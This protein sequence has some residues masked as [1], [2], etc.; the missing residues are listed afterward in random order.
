MVCDYSQFQIDHGSNAC[1]AT[2]MCCCRLFLEQDLHKEDLHRVL[3]AGAILYDK[4]RQQ[5]K[6]DPHTQQ[7]WTCVTKS[8][9]KLLRR[10]SPVFES[11]G[12]F[13]KHVDGG[14]TF[15]RVINELSSGTSRRSGVLTSDGSSYALCYDGDFYYIF[16]SHGGEPPHEDEAVFRRTR[17]RNVFQAYVANEVVAN[18]SAQFSC[19]LFDQS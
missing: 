11:N 14:C 7:Y 17:D 19:V 12:F 1:M 18:S 15:D 4:W 13:N 16:N 8:F 10:M 3:H 2:A 5:H 9:P 6:D